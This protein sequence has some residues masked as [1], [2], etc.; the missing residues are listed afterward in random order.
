MN[1]L[2][3]KLENSYKQ[4]LGENLVGIYIHGS[5]AFGCFSWERS[6]VDFIAV[7]DEPLSQE[8]RLKLLQTLEDLRPLTPPKGFEMSV[9]LRKYCEN[10]VYPT[11]F[12]QHFGNDWLEKYLAN[13]LSICGDGNQIDYDL[14]AHFTVIKSVG[15]VLCGE[16]IEK[17]FGIVPK[18]D[19]WDSIYRDIENAEEDVHDNPVYV[20]L[21]LCRVYAF[22]K[23][24][25][26]LSKE[27]G[28]KWGLENLP[29]EYHGVIRDMLAMYMKGDKNAGIDD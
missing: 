24:G 15:V 9:V 16:P 22:V 25:L 14:A 28:G 19:Y 11:P 6:D 10:F 23:E 13:P 3:A 4:I 29:T 20:I 21:N 18:E 2:L 5:I 7:V 27:Q 12:E 1:E 8:I 17:V 26:V